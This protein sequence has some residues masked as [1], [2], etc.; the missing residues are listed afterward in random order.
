MDE[1]LQPAAIKRRARRHDPEI[2]MSANNVR[3]VI[4]VFLRRG[5]VTSVLERGKTHPRYELTETGRQLQQL[6]LRA[7]TTTA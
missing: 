6:L 4:Q 3:D 7:E 1:P 5:I 2:R